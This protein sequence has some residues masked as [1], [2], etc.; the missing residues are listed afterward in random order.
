MGVETGCFQINRANRKLENVNSLNSIRWQKGRLLKKREETNIS[1]QLIQFKK[2]GR[3]NIFL[4][5][6]LITKINF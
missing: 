2:L 1:S 5:E 3:I 6:I 4:L